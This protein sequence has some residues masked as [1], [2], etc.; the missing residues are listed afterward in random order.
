LSFPK[1]GRTKG[2]GEEWAEELLACAVR[3]L[4]MRFSSAAFQYVFNG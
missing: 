4:K 2:C 3:P 1:R